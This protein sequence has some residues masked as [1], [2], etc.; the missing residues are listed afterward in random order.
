MPEP[1]NTLYTFRPP[2]KPLN[3]VIAD[4]PPSGIRRF[5]D[6][7]QQMEG[8]IS[9][10]IGEPDFV[11]PAGIRAAGIAA[12][13]Q[14]CTS[15]T[16][17]SGLPALRQRICAMLASR[18]GAEYDFQSEC[19]ITVGVSE[20]L[21]LALRVLLNPGDEVVI[22]DPCYVAYAPCVEFAG[23]V[24]VRVSTFAADGFRLDARAVEAAITPRTKAI[25]IASPANP[26]GATQSRADLE[27]LVALADEHDLYLVSDEI[28]DRLIYVGEHVCLGALPGARERTVVLNGFSKAYAMTGWRVGYA[29]APEPIA[30]LMTRVHQYTMLCASHISQLA[31]IEALD[32]AEED[33][34][35]MVAEYDGRRRL[36]VQ[37]LN[38]L[39][40]TCHVPQ[41]AFYAFPS[42]RSSGLSSEEFAERLLMEEHVAVVPG[43]AFGTAGQGHVRCSYAT[44][45]SA[46]EEALRRMGRLLSRL[47]IE[48]PRQEEENPE[49]TSNHPPRYHQGTIQGTIEAVPLT[50]KLAR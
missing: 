5:F 8:V 45:T 13:E 6:I 44:S 37:G 19:L 4:C 46:L 7:A 29:C 10:G 15:Y 47:R 38:D 11:T 17:N 2:Q 48:S 26:T 23:G 34:A 22:P 50:G 36:L 43:T 14:G 28:Y 40:L 20:G 30:T 49:T 12:L 35:L 1:L 41:G 3:T 31:A 39:G 24:A 25:L 9:L 32:H 18:Y 16:G 27:R 33:V 21:D 42:I